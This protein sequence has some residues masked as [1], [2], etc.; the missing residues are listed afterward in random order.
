M[1]GDDV[2]AR[3]SRGDL[4]QVIRFAESS[5]AY[6]E[7][8]YDQAS[9]KPRTKGLQVQ[10]HQRRCLRLANSHIALATAYIRLQVGDLSSAFET[11]IG[12]YKSAARIFEEGDHL[13]FP[14][15]AANVW[16]TLGTTL[17][18]YP[19]ENRVHYAR[20]AIEA[21][22]RA[23]GIATPY[24]ASIEAPPEAMRNRKVWK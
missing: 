6:D 15:Y 17:L 1:L 2:R 19:T 18:S 20:Q 13:S 12:H 3:L 11:A 22:H 16:T 21:F 9:S 5:L 23:K 24:A 14:L 4:N 10:L 8:A 7:A